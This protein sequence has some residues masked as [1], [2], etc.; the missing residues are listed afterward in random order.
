MAADRMAH[1]DRLPC[2]VVDTGNPYRAALADPEE[3]P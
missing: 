3:K 1:Q 2:A